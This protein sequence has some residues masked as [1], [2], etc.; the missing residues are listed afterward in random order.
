[1]G[2]IKK[3]VIGVSN[4]SEVSN[5]VHSLWFSVKENSDERSTTFLIPYPII[6]L[7]KKKIN[8]EKITK[9]SKMRIIINK[10]IRKEVNNG[11]SYTIGIRK[12]DLPLGLIGG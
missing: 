12:W 9:F 10:Q 4:S 3:N 11:T 2:K 1:M 6:I 7:H 8:K 5:E